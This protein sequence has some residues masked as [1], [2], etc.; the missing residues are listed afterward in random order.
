[1]SASTLITTAI[2]SNCCRAAEQLQAEL[3][4]IEADSYAKFVQTCRF[5]KELTPLLQKVLGQTTSP[6][7]N[8]L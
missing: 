8:Q 3:L 4:A 5:N 1:M 2:A 6:I 7:S